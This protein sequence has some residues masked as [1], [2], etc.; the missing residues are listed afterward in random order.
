MGKPDALSRRSDHP[1]GAADNR[2]FT[3]LPKKLFEVRATETVLLDADDSFLVRIRECNEVDDSVA[4]ALKALSDNVLVSDEWAHNDGITLH[5]GRVYVPNNAELRHDIVDAHHSPPTV[6]HPGKWKTLELVSRNYWWPGISRYIAK[7]TSKC[8]SCN[9]AKT[10]PSK[11]VGKLMPNA[12]PSECWQI[13]SVDMIGE[14]PDSRGFNAI[15]VVVDRLSKRIHAIPTVTSLNSAGVARLFL[16]NVWRHHGLPE[17]V[18]SDRGPAF[19][20]RF[21]KD[22]A[23][24]LGIKLT[25]STAYHLENFH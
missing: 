23:G 2:G 13:V 17:Q 22:L 16:E 11:R 6:G 8:D 20:S 10:F 12:I 9:R 3:L 5:R 21:A 18:L 4:K 24:L 15:L 25:P 1:N 14:L 7:F 19:V